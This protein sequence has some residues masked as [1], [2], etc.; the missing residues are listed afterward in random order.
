MF[1]DAAS[2]NKYGYRKYIL[3]KFDSNSIN[4]TEIN[5]LFNKLNN[6]KDIYYLFNILLISKNYCHL[7]INNKYLLDKME[8]LI[9]K[10]AP[11]YKYLFGYVWITLYMEECTKKSRTTINDRYVFDLETACRLPFFPF[12]SN[13]AH[14]NP[15]LPLLISKKV[16]NF[17]ESFRSLGM[18]SGHNGY[19][20]CTPEEFKTRLKIF[21]SGQSSDELSIF[22]NV[23]WEGIAITGSIM[24]ACLQKRNPL[25]DLF[26]HLPNDEAIYNR[27]F[28][29]YYAT[30]DIDI[31]CNY[32][33]KTEFVDKVHQLYNCIKNNIM[34]NNN[35]NEAGN[36]VK[37]IPC[38]TL[39]IFVKT[40]YIKKYMVNNLDL[41]L[42]FAPTLENIIKNKD[43]DVIKEFF[44]NIYTDRLAQKSDMPSSPKYYDIYN[45]VPIEDTKIYIVENNDINGN[46]NH[47]VNGDEHK[48]DDIDLISFSENL[49]Y[50][51]ESPFLLRKIELFQIKYTDFFSTVSKFHLPCV[52]AFYNGDKV[53]LLPSTISAFMTMTNIDYKYY[54]G[55]NPACE[56]NLKNNQRGYSVVLNDSEKIR[57]IDYC[58]RL[59]KWKK[60]MK[61]NVHNKQNINNILE[62]K[63]ISN[64]Y[65]KPRWINFDLYE[66]CDPVDHNYSNVINTM[67]H[68]KKDLANEYKLRFGYDQTESTINFLNY[69][70][71]NEKGYINPLKLWLIDAAFD[72][73]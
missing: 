72:E 29:E 12:N 71:I 35:N 37:L 48:I 26:S 58:S 69:K 27:Y 25:V 41:N 60:I 14:M 55:S 17:R 46:A 9:K 32:T 52:R 38:K 15:Y 24:T 63:D 61:L 28:Q 31:M 45:I 10:Y 21:S 6:K 30:S 44:Y 62:V 43:I 36:S 33:I 54:S 19:G 1:V 20:L 64:N 56:I 47:D 4:Q 16:L 18:I 2:Y 8:P 66:L 34:N 11:L 40:E 73:L 51:I 23:D 59:P 3:P 49:K 57:L 65:Y 7:V 13:D 50:K 5:E 42:P 53:Y 67:V 68:T 70:T 22:K 39:A